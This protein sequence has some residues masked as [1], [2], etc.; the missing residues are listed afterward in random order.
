MSHN[1]QNKLF[2][3]ARKAVAAAI[4]ETGSSSYQTV[5]DRSIVHYNEGLRKFLA[6]IGKSTENVPEGSRYPSAG[7]R[8]L[9]ETDPLLNTA[10]IANDPFV[11]RVAVPALQTVIDG[12]EFPSFPTILR[13]YCGSYALQGLEGSRPRRIPFVFP[14]DTAPEE[15]EGWTTVK[16]RKGDG[17][18]RY[19][20]PSAE[21]KVAFLYHPAMVALW[22][23]L[24]QSPEWDLPMNPPS[25]E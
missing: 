16:R 18:N 4:R 11:E 13:A 24:P 20:F 17:V 15:E 14:N 12:A 5:L 25:Y 6:G 19:V 7:V 22:K 23:P 9:F 8:R 1:S 3:H 2:H 10:L 21:A